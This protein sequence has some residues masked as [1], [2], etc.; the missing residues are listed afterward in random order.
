L[1]D[2]DPK[3]SNKINKFIKEE[4]VVVRIS[5]NS[6]VTINTETEDLNKKIER[7]IGSL[8]PSEIDVLFGQVPGGKYVDLCQIA[9]LF[10]RHPVF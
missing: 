7:F 9:R 8:N 6:C 5:E 2:L 4:V 1:G 3:L 10:Y